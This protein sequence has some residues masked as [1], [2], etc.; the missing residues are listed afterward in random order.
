LQEPE[1]QERAS[2]PAATEDNPLGA[3]AGSLAVSMPFL[4][5]CISPFAT[6]PTRL[7]GSLG[8]K[9]EADQ[10]HLFFSGPGKYFWWW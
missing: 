10:I 9:N 4:K 5:F 3:L 6:Q 7:F 8:K 1:N 2:K